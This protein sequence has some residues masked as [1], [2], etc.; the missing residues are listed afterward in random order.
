MYFTQHIF[1]VAILVGLAFSAQACQDR[2]APVELYDD[3][4]AVPGKYRLRGP[5]SLS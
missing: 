4:A 5:A 3:V 1:T 2:R